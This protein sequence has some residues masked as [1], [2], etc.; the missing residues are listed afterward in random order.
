MD[1]V[2]YE[3]GMMILAP[4]LTLV[5]GVSGAV[6]GIIDPKEVSVNPTDL[7][8]RTVNEMFANDRR[9]IGFGDHNVSGRYWV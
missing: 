3:P 5:G 1:T 2:I 9:S 4:V 8:S 6:I 7:Q